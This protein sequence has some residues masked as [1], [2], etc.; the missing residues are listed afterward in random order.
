MTLNVFGA[1]NEVWKVFGRLATSFG[2]DENFGAKIVQT[3][4]RL[5]PAE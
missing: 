1:L 5:N 2:G 4:A 3:V